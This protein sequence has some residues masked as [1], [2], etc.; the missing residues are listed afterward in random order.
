VKRKQAETMLE[1]FA[2][3]D[4]NPIIG[5]KKID[6]GYYLNLDRLDECMKDLNRKGKPI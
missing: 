6:S 3:I 1:F 2:Y 4:E 5:K